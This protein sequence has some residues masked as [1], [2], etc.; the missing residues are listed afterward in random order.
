M[1]LVI[2]LVTLPLMA[3]FF[4]PVYAS[5]S[6]S[7]NPQVVDSNSKAM[8]PSLAFDSKGYPHISYYAPGNY[9]RNLDTGGYIY[10]PGTLKYASW[11]GSNWQIQTIDS[12]PGAGLPSSLAI[13]KNGNPHI[14]YV[15]TTQDKNNSAN[16]G[17]SSTLKYASW[18]GSSWNIETIETYY[19]VGA[20]TI[21]LDSHDN[22]HIAYQDVGL[23]GSAS[24][25]ETVWGGTGYDTV[26]INTSASSVKY[27]SQSEST[28][29]IATI[30]SNLAGY[31]LSFAL[32]SND[33]PHLTYY[34][35]THYLDTKGPAGPLKY[36]SWDGSSWNIQQFGG[37]TPEVMSLALDS[38]NK[39]HIAMQGDAEVYM[40]W[41]GTGW[42]ISSI[43]IFGKWGS[44]ISLII[45]SNDKPYV[46]YSN[47][48]FDSTTAKFASWNGSAWVPQVVAEYTAGADDNAGFK[49]TSISLD[50][51]GKPVIAY[52][53]HYRLAIAGFGE[54][55]P[56]PSTN[57][58]R[59]NTPIDEL[60]VSFNP[61]EI[62]LLVAIGIIV[63]L[64]VVI[65]LMQKKL[66]QV[67]S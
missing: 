20:C 30:D 6:S 55:K 66:K 47:C 34:S 54:F 17:Y 27:A 23:Y 51:T 44:G 53:D 63:I 13:D 56:S 62:S 41:N 49:T 28:W 25:N 58:N 38:Y 11:D 32:D 8:S 52:V 9:S 33:N 42:D 50:S 19:G 22:P 43:D 64:L 24:L 18:T 21:I 35:H 37:G 15:Y 14:A 10:E 4:Y 29:K 3:P 31:D 12:S 67:S 5:D 36:A 2:T 46:S 26:S 7:W 57:S 61:I 48:Q 1:L 40:S 16:Y 60:Q 45:G 65:A 59:S 39:P